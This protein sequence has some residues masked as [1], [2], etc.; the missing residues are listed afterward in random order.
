MQLIFDLRRRITF[1][2]QI[3]NVSSI[4]DFVHFQKN[5][6]INS[7]KPLLHNNCP[8]KMAEPLVSNCQQMNNEIH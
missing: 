6:H 8:S 3:F 4:L 2:K 1:Q 7:L 5:T